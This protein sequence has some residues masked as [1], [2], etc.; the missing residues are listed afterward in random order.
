MSILNKLMKKNVNNNPLYIK[1]KEALLRQEFKIDIKGAYFLFGI[2]YS[3]SNLEMMK[4]A[5]LSNTLSEVKKNVLYDVLQDNIELYLVEDSNDK[6][7]MILLLDPYELYETETILEI[8]PVNNKD[9]EME[10][11]FP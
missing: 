5:V 11:I 4:Q 2:P 9:F 1:L 8:I 10:P 7:Y 3:I 6:S